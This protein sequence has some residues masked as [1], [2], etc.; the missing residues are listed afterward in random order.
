M[1]QKNKNL[2]IFSGS[3]RFTY[4]GPADIL[5]AGFVH[6]RYRYGYKNKIQPETYI[7]YQWDNKRGLMHR[8]LA[9]AN[10]RYNLW[11]GDKWD[12][13]T[14]LGLIIEQEQWNYNAV[15]SAK[16]PVNASPVEKNYLKLNAL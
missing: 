6:L 15:D 7:Q 1:L 9:G 3:Y 16:I 14:G 12:F 13:N 11:K 2:F 10:I 8:V 4:N 5:N